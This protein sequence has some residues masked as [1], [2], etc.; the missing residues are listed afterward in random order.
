LSDVN[1]VKQ[2][3]LNQQLQDW[4]VKSTDASVETRR[5]GISS[6]IVSI[7]NLS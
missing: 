2:E 4:G 3:R 1:T 7:Q 6:V 5:T